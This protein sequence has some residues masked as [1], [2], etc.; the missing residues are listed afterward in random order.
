MHAET[1]V[2][3]GVDIVRYNGYVTILNPLTDAHRTFRIRT[4]AE[5]A[6]FAPGARVIGLLTGAD[7][8]NDY[9]SFGFVNPQGKVYVWKSKQ[10]GKYDEYAKLFNHHGWYARER[11]LEYLHDVR[12]RRCNRTLTDPTSIELGIGP[13]CRKAAA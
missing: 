4:Q 13:V 5:D 6:K 8:E 7:N 10:G 2:Q 11:G 1:T 12:C 9:T 3:S